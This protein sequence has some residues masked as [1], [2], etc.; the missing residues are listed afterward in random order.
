MISRQNTVTRLGLEPR[1]YGLKVLFRVRQV[2]AVCGSVRIPGRLSTSD[3]TLAASLLTLSLTLCRIDSRPF[4][5][6]T[7]SSAR[8]LGLEVFSKI[9]QRRYGGAT[10]AL[11]GRYAVLLSFLR[12][13]LWRI[14][15][16]SAENA[17]II[18]K[19]ST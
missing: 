15:S 10:V 5:F 16:A 12:F 7:L 3:Y 2:S 14:F 1:T 9:L 13:R 11:R 4:L 18:L 19:P 8:T 6:G 17:R